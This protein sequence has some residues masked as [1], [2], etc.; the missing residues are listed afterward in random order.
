MESFMTWMN[1][2][3]VLSEPLFDGIEWIIVSL[4][5]GGA[6][7]MIMLLWWI[8]KIEVANPAG[9]WWF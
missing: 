6:F 9:S 7:A 8:S 3:E 4:G 2:R 1:W 5:A